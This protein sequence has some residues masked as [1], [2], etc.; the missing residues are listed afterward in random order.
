MEPWKS[1]RSTVG[2]STGISWARRIPRAALG[3]DQVTV[4][5][6]LGRLLIPGRG[7]ESDGEGRRGGGGARC[8]YC[9]DEWRSVSSER[10][11]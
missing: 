10:P 8:T 9:R 1:V 6:F 2:S 5:Q 4:S 7:T 3:G 11:S